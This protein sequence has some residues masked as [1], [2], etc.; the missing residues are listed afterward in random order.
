VFDPDCGGTLDIQNGWA[1]DTPFTFTVYGGPG[2]Y[3]HPDARSAHPTAG[4]SSGTVLAT[5]VFTENPGTDGS[6]YSFGPFSAAD[7]ESVGSKRLL[8]LTVAGGPQ[9]PFDGGGRADL[10]IYN[11]ALSTS[12][13]TNTAPDGARIVGFSWTFLIPQA[14]YST[15]PRLFPYAASD[16]S[17]FAQHNWDYDSDASGP[18]AAGITI[19][20]PLRTISVPDTDVSRDNEERSSSYAIQDGER[21]TTWATSCWARPSGA[22]GDNLVTFWATNQDGRAL[23]IFA[24][25]TNGP[26]P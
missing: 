20:T 8:K 6:W 18:G 22:I 26:P 17:T 25:S 14:T 12:S 10:N 19:V 3:T 7:G 21:N 4:A 23:A 15:P 1:W 9:P 5:A 16:T 24:R 13:A 11:V 2:T